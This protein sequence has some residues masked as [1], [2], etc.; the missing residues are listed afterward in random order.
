[1]SLHRPWLQALVLCLISITAAFAQST[2]V[3]AQRMLDVRTGKIVSPASLLVTGGLIQAVNPASPPASATVLDLGDV[4]LLPGFID[5]HVH[6]SLREASAYR[7]D[8]LG[9]SGADA[10]LRSTASARKILMAGFTT[11]RDLGQL[12]VTPDLIVVA[13]S[14]A[15][16]AG[17]IEAP[18]IVASGHPISITGGHIDPEMHASVAANIL[19][20]GPEHGIADGP[21]QVTKAVR[22]Q[23]KRG[24]KV[25]KISA[26]AGVFSLEDSPGAQQMTDAEIR[27]A[28]EEAGRHGIKV[29][30][31]AHG[32]EGIL[33][34][35]KAGV[36]SIEHG[37]LLTDE[38]IRLMKER[39]T[40]LVPTTGL[41]DTIDYKALPP[42]VRQKG[43]TLI[44]LARANLKKAAIAGVRIALGTDAPL[45]PFGDNAKEFAAMVDRG[46][47]PIESLRA[48]TLNA[49]DLLGVTDRGELAPG[50]FADIVAVPGNPLQDIRATEKV[51]FV[52]KAGRIYRRP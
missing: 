35:V 32:S 48:G 34:A 26:T 18:R 31:H 9:E 2:L 15:S 33:A 52:M 41:G 6:V 23:I 43:E 22:H 38:I 50:K 36:A 46:L 20:L 24:A 28:V 17:W 29:A 4:T 27:A 49:A 12:H 30:A 13:L 1:M 40:F 21:D 7:A 8:I 45:L 44:P 16:D 47:T 3:R 11:I 10:A 14:R 39:G 25:I 5:M 37:S 42:V 19:H 51:V